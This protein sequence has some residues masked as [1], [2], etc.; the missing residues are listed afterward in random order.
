MNI[1]EL[2][3]QLRKR[4]EVAGHLSSN[5][6]KNLSDE[7]VIRAY[8]TCNECQK[9]QLDA[10]SLEQAVASMEDIAE[11]LD[12]AHQLQRH[13][14]TQSAKKR[15]RKKQYRKRQRPS[16]YKSPTLTNSKSTTIWDAANEW[17]EVN[18][19]RLN[20]KCLTSD[21][22]TTL[23]T[24]LHAKWTGQSSQKY[25]FLWSPTS[26][27]PL[28]EVGGGVFRMVTAQ[29]KLLTI[30]TDGGMIFG[31]DA[32]RGQVEPLVVVASSGWESN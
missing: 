23:M 18:F 20:G 1:K 16:R 7:D 30:S 29:T 3:S 6:V 27:V 15:N 25:L 26:S 19:P 31:V 32:M 13:C 2:A 14:R 21:E 24:S 5:M 28:F 12:L 9:Q 17:A 4:L 10:N 11:F 22:L 8:T